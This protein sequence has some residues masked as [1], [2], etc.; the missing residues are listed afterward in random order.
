MILEFFWGVLILG[1]AVVYLLPV[2]FSALTSAIPSW[3]AR[4]PAFS[5]PATFGAGIFSILFTG[6]VLALIIFALRRVAP[7]QAKEA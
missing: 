3:G 4:F 6:V 1:V 2:I 7:A 5:R